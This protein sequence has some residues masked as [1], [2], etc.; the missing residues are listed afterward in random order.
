MPGRIVS[1]HRNLLR[2]DTVEQAL[3][4]ELQSAVEL[5]TEEK[6]KEGVSP[7]VARRQAL[8]ELGVEQVKED[9]RSIQAGRLLE[10]LAKDVRFGIRTLAKSPGFTAAIITS[11]A[12]GIA[13][14]PRFSASPTDCF[15]GCCP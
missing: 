9:V 11:V 1:L 8:M 3:D 14:P 12:L 10:D 15:G 2:K 7:S 13:A 4:D 5:L 6:I